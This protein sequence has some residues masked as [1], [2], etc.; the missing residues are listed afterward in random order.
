MAKISLKKNGS[1]AAKSGGIKLPIMVE[2]LGMAV[3][4]VVIISIALIF[5]SS[6][7]M[8]AA[9]QQEALTGL[10]AQ[11][12]NI[13]TLYDGMD[14]DSYY[15]VGDNVYKGSKQ[16]SG[17]DELLDAIK[18][19][20]GYDVTFFWGDTRAITSIVDPATNERII[21]TQ[22]SAEV[23][24][25]VINKGEEY[26][27]T[28]IKI[29]G[30]DYYGYYIPVINIDGSIVGMS[31][32]GMPDAQVNASISKTVSS[33]TGLGIFLLIVGA[34]ICTLIA[35]SLALSIISMNKAIE[36]L[37]EGNLA[38]EVPAKAMARG[39]E[40]GV[41][42]KSIDGLTKK[43]IEIISSIKNSSSVLLNSGNSLDEMA[44]Q[45]SETT[46]EISRA[47]EDISR[48]AVSQA[49]EIETA[50]AEIG[51]MG[52]VIEEIVTS[53]GDLGNASDEMKNASD[54]SERIIKELSAS[55]DR[56]IGA[57]KKIGEQVN[58]TNESVQAIRQA[59]ELITAIADETSLLS[60]N[61]SIEAARAGENGRGFAVVASE[62]QKLAE[63]SNASAGKIKEI[64]DALLR[65]AE[66][67]VKVMDEVE[68]IIA[69]QQKKLDETKE[70]F[71]QVTVGVNSSRRGTQ[72]IQ[73][74]TTVCDTSRA[75]VVDVISNLSAISQENAAS[76]EETTASME[77]LNATINLLA[78]AARN[79]K[80][81][82]VELDNDMQ[83]F[84]L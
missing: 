38:V 24:E 59:I 47:I 36:Q 5:V 43:L 14:K 33:V 7:K 64:I 19:S 57:V 62:I 26:S 73:G 41:M 18:A 11:A 44:T 46:D 27:T 80:N 17:N 6:S 74:H 30:I 48:G 82:S 65:D 12:Y 58:A 67:T 54:E 42:A 71:S 79:L 2:L 45:T 39:D 16:L 22:A 56:T 84:K 51:N 83:F 60:L 76:T 31:F 25:K 72:A 15:T 21:G 78:E 37:A 75:S 61:A 1:E 55:N 32:A 49:E 10:R 77:E 28:D 35:R 4:P 9:L 13:V 53:V 3:V 63:Q 70:K 69:D 81:L 20:T 29:N 40:I 52:N 50:S 66:E 23:I 34:V 8:K 68:E